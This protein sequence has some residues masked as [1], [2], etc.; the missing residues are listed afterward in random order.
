MPTDALLPRAWELRATASPAGVG[1]HC[2]AEKQEGACGGASSTPAEQKPAPAQ[3]WPTA[4]GGGQRPAAR[5]KVWI[6]SPLL[7]QST[8]PAAEVGPQ[9]PTA[10]QS[11]A[12][13]SEPPHRRSFVAYAAQK[14][15]A[16]RTPGRQRKCGRLVTPLPVF[17][18]SYLLLDGTVSARLAGSTPSSKTTGSDAQARA[19]R[20]PFSGSVCSHNMSIQ[21]E[22]RIQ[23]IALRRYPAHPHRP[24]APMA[25]RSLHGSLFRDPLYRRLPKQWT[26]ATTT[27]TRTTATASGQLLA[28]KP[29]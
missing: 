1:G 12:A 2:G 11:T 14:I 3:R 28:A 19:T 7:Q 20:A 24:A 13:V 8:M 6:R 29:S 25:T 10:E 9:V 5:R 22:L 4:G 23:N 15:A 17:R 27:D 26:C 18:R 16:A 21:R